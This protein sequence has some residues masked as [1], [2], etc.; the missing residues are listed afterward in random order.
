MLIL[1][2]TACLLASI[3]GMGTAWHLSKA[4]HR[5]WSLLC[6]LA[7]FVLVVLYGDKLLPAPWNLNYEGFFQLSV[8]PDACLAFAIPVLGILTADM[9]GSRALRFG[10]LGVMCAAY[11]KAVWVG[12]LDSMTT[13]HELTG[14]HTEIDKNGVCRQTTGYTCGPAAAV[15]ALRRLGVDADEKELAIEAETGRFLGTDEFRLVRVMNDA[16]A[17]K[18]LRFKVADFQNADDLNGLFPFIAIQHLYG[19]EY[20]YIVIL[21]IKGNWVEY[22]D[23]LPGAI[24]RMPR[25][26]FEKDWQKRGIILTRGS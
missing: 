15:T 8:I 25:A 10:V 18:G 23:P 6:A 7:V 1:R 21:G 14:L 12:P 16:L 26:D 13:V 24:T 17:Q 5:N 19:Q 4:R 2:V 22:A 9:L 11:F 20:H 3:A